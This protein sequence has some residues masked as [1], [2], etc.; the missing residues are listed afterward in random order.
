M[1]TEGQGLGHRPI[2]TATQ[3]DRN[4]ERTQTARN[5]ERDDGQRGGQG[6]RRTGQG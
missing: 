1:D 4:R 6:N 2:E 5:R 3:M